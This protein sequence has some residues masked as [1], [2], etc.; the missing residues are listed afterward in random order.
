MLTQIMV[1]AHGSFLPVTVFRPGII[2]DDFQDGHI[3]SFSNLYYPL[4]LIANGQLRTIPGSGAARLDLVT[5]DLAT[6]KIVALLQ[7]PA[8]CGRIDDRIVSVQSLEQKGVK[9]PRTP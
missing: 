4:Q 3:A 5:V 6:D 7:S 1:R 8:S 2:V 9:L